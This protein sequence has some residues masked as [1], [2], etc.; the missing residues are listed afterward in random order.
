MPTLFQDKNGIW[1]KSDTESEKSYRSQVNDA[2]NHAYGNSL[3][4]SID[5]IKGTSDI[6][7]GIAQINTELDKVREEIGQ[8]ADKIDVLAKANTKILHLEKKL[9]YNSWYFKNASYDYLE[10]DTFENDEK[11]FHANIA[12]AQL[13]PEINKS[14][15]YSIYRT[16]KIV[17]KLS[18]PI[19]RYMMHVEYKV[20]NE[21]GLVVEVSFDSGNRYHTVLSTV[22]DENVTYYY[23]YP[24][25]CDCDN[26]VP[27]TDADSFI[28]RFRLLANQEGA[29]VCVYSYGILVA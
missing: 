25:F 9:F 11:M 29:G 3:Q 15:K 21:G 20:E 24:D 5:E 6:R 27:E 1:Y 13:V 23:Q 14:G 16:T 28:V 19:S 7:S 2:V 12:D 26:N 22:K 10:F 4:H 17:P 18:Q 8:S